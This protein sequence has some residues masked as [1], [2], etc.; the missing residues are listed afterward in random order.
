MSRENCCSPKCLIIL[1]VV[2]NILFIIS[3][4]VLIGFGI[5]I[6]VDNNISTI[7]NRFADTSHLQGQTL[8][9]FPYILI[10]AGVLT[11]LV[12]IIGFMGMSFFS[13]YSHLFIQHIYFH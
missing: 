2:L 7:L 1:L 4:I 12:S 13:I 9:Y 8:A 10:G 5:Y 3:G 6:A 11:F